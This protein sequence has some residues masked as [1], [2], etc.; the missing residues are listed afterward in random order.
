MKN[1]YLNLLKPVGHR[2]M[3]SKSYAS[4]VRCFMIIPIMTN[5]KIRLVWYDAGNV[6]EYQTACVGHPI[7]ERGLISLN[8]KNKCIRITITL[9]SY[10]K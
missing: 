7:D 6:M 10:L 1:L 9:M 2:P 3:L 4:L 5:T 8:F